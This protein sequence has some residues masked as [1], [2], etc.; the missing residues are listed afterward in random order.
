MEALFGALSYEDRTTYVLSFAA[1]NPPPAKLSG[2]LETFG[3]SLQN[4]T[5]REKFRLLD[6][7]SRK[8]TSS[9]LSLAMKFQCLRF[10]NTEKDRTG[11]SSFMALAS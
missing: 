4:M 9:R 8:I 7:F 10:V 5:P 6:A 1:K 11:L 2:E 3:N